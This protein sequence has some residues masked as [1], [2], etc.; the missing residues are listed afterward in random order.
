MSANK[1]FFLTLVLLGA[2]ALV[3][4]CG[5]DSV[6]PTDDEAPILPP[7]GVVAMTSETARLELSWDP[8]SHPRLAGYQVYRL[9]VD[10]QELEKLTSTPITQTM[11]GDQSARRG[12]NYEYRVTAVTKS[13]KESAYTAIPVILQLIPKD[14]PRPEN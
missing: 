11:Y 3:A 14:E 12:V 8:N 2:C 6:A 7:T 4:G 9:D 10:S 5:S 13:N 1:F